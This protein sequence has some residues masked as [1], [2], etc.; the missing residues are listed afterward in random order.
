MNTHNIAEALRA[1]ECVLLLGPRAATFE[2]EYLQDLLA[3]RIAQR[4]RLPVGIPLNLPHIA[5]QFSL[6]FK[7]G[8]QAL[9]KTGELLREFYAEFPR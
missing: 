5:K 8:T 7:D 6:Q 9:E 2:G 1:D 4:L 3:N